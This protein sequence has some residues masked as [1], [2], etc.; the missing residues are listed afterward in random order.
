MQSGILCADIGTSSLKAAFITEDGTVLKFI[1]LLFPQ[2]VHAVDWVQTFFA[3]WRSLPADYAIEAICISG[4]GPSLVA[5]PQ[6][7]RAPEASINSA[8]RVPKIHINGDR[9][10]FAVSLPPDD[11]MN[12]IIDAI[13]NDTLFLWNEP[14]PQGLTVSGPQCY[15]VPALQEGT[16]SIPPAGASLF[17]PRIA[18]FRAKYPDVFDSAAQL[19]SGSEYVSYLLTGA[20]V[21]SLPDPRYE[22]AYWSKEELFRFSEALHIDTERLAGLLPPFTAAGTVIGRFCGIPVVAGVPDFIAA[23]IGTGT[24]TAGT[25]CD[26]AGS[27]EGINVCISQPHR[28]EK[29]LLLPSVMPDLW[30]LSSV[31]PSSGAAFSDFLITHGLRGN[32]YIAAMERIAAEPFAASGAYPATFAGQGRAFVEELA[33]RIRYGCDLLEQASG[34]H[35]VYTLSGGQAH[36]A[37]WCQ[38]KADITGRTFA[39]PAFADGELIG[40]A[41]LAL[42]GL[43]RGDNLA[44]IAQRLIR[45]KRYYEPEPA[46]AHRYTEKYSRC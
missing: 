32:D 24:L 26:R 43:G 34:F 5:V 13:K 36:N 30:N 7:R 11:V 28:A 35:P 38:M 19:F 3:A 22:A 40:D 18:A 1:R 6:N 29:T 20:A 15:T 45:I 4:N 27:S 14:A 44:A 33:F 31:I 37:I 12:G 2:P 8:G 23:L 41:A 42:Y 9:H 17:L 25:A 16:A 10:L 39:L 21:T 46:A